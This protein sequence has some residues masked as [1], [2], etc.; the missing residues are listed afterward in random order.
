VVV[1]AV[2]TAIPM[3]LMMA[4]DIPKWAIRAIDKLRRGF[5]WT[6]YQNANGGNCLVSWE[7]V[8]RP[9]R[10][11]ALGILNLQLMG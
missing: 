11:G 4:L 3:H 8:Q 6:G 5:L 7:K 2:L 1:C 10:Y 9:L